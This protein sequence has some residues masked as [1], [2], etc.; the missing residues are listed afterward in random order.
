[1]PRAAAGDRRIDGGITKTA[2]PVVQ[3]D[4]KDVALEFRLVEVVPVLDGWRTTDPAK[5]QE[6][7]AP[8]LRR[9]GGDALLQVGLIDAFDSGKP[10]SADFGSFSLLVASIL[11]AGSAGT[12]ECR[13]DSEGCK[14]S[15]DGVPHVACFQA[16]PTPGR[17]DEPVKTK[18]AR[19]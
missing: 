16:S 8:A 1:L 2:F 3:P 18:T 10:E 13:S 5:G 9:L 15:I 11:G 6:E 7:H 4:T 17:I 12:D 19:F 14:P